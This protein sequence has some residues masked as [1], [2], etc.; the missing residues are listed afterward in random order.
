MSGPLSA[1]ASRARRLLVGGLLGAVVVGAVAAVVGWFVGGREGALVAGGAVVAVTAF[2]ALGQAV[3]V[4]CADLDA[5]TVLVAALAS[6]VVRVG[7][8]G[9]LVFGVLAQPGPWTTQRP[10]AVG[11]MIATLVGW[12]AGE[13]W[14]YAHLRI[15]VYDEP[16][17]D[18]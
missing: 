13:I 15:P 3:Q 9:G 4:W 11:A 5:R 18:D 6:Y 7:A 10:V 14:V 2:F 16:D 17:R 1:S 8:L 12:L